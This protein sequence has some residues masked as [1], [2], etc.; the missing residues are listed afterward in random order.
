MGSMG[1]RYFINLHINP[2]GASAGSRARR[3]V[4]ALPGDEMYRLKSQIGIQ[5]QQF[6]GQKRKGDRYPRR[7]DEP[8]R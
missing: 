8:N 7:K 3:G 1:Y 6:A 2:M 4:G 5:I